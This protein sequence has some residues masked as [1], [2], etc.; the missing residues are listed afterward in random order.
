MNFNYF[1]AKLEKSEKYPNIYF[2]IHTIN[3]CFLGVEFEVKTTIIVRL[4]AIHIGMNILKMGSA[5]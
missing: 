3:F 4:I 1:T 2:I 5:W